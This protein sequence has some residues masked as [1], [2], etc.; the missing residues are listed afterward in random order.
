M[1]IVSPRHPYQRSSEERTGSLVTKLYLN[2]APP[3]GAGGILSSIYKHATPSRGETHQMI[4]Y[5]R[6]RFAD[7]AFRPNLPT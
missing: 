3:N 7:S 5:G 4:P 2:S 6:G 1:F